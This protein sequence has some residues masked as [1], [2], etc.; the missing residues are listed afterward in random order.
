MIIGK[1]HIGKSIIATIL[2]LL[3]VIYVP[4]PTNNNIAF[5]FAL[6][7]TIYPLIN[8]TAVNGTC[9][10]QTNADMRILSCSSNTSQTF[11]PA[12]VYNFTDEDCPTLNNFNTLYCSPIQVK[13]DTCLTQMNSTYFNQ[14]AFMQGVQTF[15]NQSE[16]NKSGLDVYI[17]DAIFQAN[18]QTSNICQK[19][20]DNITVGYELLEYYN[21][22]LARTQGALDICMSNITYFQQKENDIRD[23]LIVE[24]GIMFI[25]LLGFIAIGIVMTYKKYGG[26]IKVISSNLPPEPFIQPKQEQRIPF[27]PQRPV[28]KLPPTPTEEDDEE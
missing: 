16:V 17:V 10:I 9:I 3:I 23:E 14:T 6:N 22:S 4:L 11:T 26:S 15:L 19:I 12:Y 24:R 18:N 2:T 25:L 8:A 28:Q 21:I 7:K 27:I 5:A 1:R 13:L 20:I